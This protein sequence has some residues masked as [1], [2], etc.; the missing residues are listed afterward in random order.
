MVLLYAR[1]LFDNS[2]LNCAEKHT[3]VQ[4]FYARIYE[5]VAGT[6]I[7]IAVVRAEVDSANGDSPEVKDI[8]PV[9]KDVNGYLRTD[10]QT[11]IQL[12]HVMKYTKCQIRTFH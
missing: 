7:R 11:E 3:N 1:R 4:L 8:R 9:V 2:K 6:S 12:L 10:L 5:A